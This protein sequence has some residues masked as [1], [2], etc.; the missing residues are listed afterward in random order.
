MAASK[1]TVKS[2]WKNIEQKGFRF[3]CVGCQKERRLSAPAQVGSPQ[4]FA[5]IVFTTL[6]FS[7]FTW[8]WMSW[9][10]IVVFAL[11]VGLVFETFYRLKM[12]TALICPECTFDPMLYLVDR[13][14]AV[15]QV[16]QTWR[17]KFEE[18]GI[19]YPEKKRA[20]VQPVS[21]LK[22]TSL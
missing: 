18:K 7:L 19:P 22:N 9:K 2:I 20:R 5:H 3:Y 14:K 21:P 6:F 16:E 4:F 8:P 11:P 17:K 1:S 13:E 10:G 12:R 15:R